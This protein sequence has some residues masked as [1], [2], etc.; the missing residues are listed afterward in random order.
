MNTCTRRTFVSTVAAGS[1]SALAGKSRRA[2]ILLPADVPQAAFADF[3]IG[4][5]S[6]N[7]DALRQVRDGFGAGQR[8]IVFG[9]PQLAG[10]LQDVKRPIAIANL[11]AHINERRWTPSPYIDLVSLDLW[12]SQWRLGQWAAGSIGKRA[13]IASSLQD[14]GYDYVRAFRL[15]FEQAGGQIVSESVVHGGAPVADLATA[16]LVYAAFA[17]SAIPILPSIPCLAGPGTGIPN[18]ISARSFCGDAYSE[19]AARL[20]KKSTPTHEILFRDGAKIASLA[21]VCGDGPCFDELHA[22]LQSGWSTPF[23]A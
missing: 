3:A 12:R 22:G 11:G 2:S 15:G 14:A 21:A 18:A 8:L 23:I 4:T 13:A 7:G 1:A 6:S 17:N 19:L 20:S 16:D 5:Y 9:S 10:L